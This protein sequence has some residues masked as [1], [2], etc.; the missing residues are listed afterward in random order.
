[1]AE[2]TALSSPI[3]RFAEIEGLRAWL[4]WLVVAWHVI[5]YTGL[6]ARYRVLASSAGLAHL[7]VEVFIILSGYVVTN[8]LCGPRESYGPYL[9]RRGM[10]LVP[11]YLVV[12]FA[13]IFTTG[14][15]ARAV[16]LVPWAADPGFAYR[17]TL[18]ATYASQQAYFPIHLALHATLLQGMIADSMLPFASATFVGPAWSLSLEWQFYL[19][20]PLLVGVLR[21]RRRAA[22]GMALAAIAFL[23]FRHGVFGQYRLDSALPLALPMFLTGILGR[24]A[25]P[26]LSQI[27]MPV[28]AAGILGLVAG[29]TVPEF[30]AI[31]LWLAF[32]AYLIGRQQPLHGADRTVV[33]FADLLFKGRIARWFG[34]RSYCVYLVH[35]PLLQVLLLALALRLPKNTALAAVELAALLIPLTILAAELLH[36][37]VEQPG[38]AVGKR[39]AN[40]ANAHRNLQGDRSGTAAQDRRA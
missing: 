9:L 1:M 2:H 27:R 17:S 15:G 34:A 7:S 6:N 20:A 21:D 11:T 38:I 33:Q 5:Q 32:Y 31:G 30:M 28:L 16:T 4:S 12:I 35:W 37:F 40:R 39:L 29:A 23:A 25:F 3:Q 36:H 10:R 8:L 18:L 13:G 14:L 19:I 26:V 22:T 24:L